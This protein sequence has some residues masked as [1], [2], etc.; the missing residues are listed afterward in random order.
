MLLGTHRIYWVVDQLCFLLVEETPYRSKCSV[1]GK[2]KM[3]FGRDATLVILSI[4]T[5]N[6]CLHFTYSFIST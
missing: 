6:N 3:V 2:T 4:S 1:G 5:Y